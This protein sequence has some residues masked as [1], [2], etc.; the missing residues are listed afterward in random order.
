MTRFLIML[1]EQ[2]IFWTPTDPQP[3]PEMSLL[4]VLI[5]FEPKN[6]EWGNHYTHSCFALLTI[7]EFIEIQDTSAVQLW[8]VVSRTEA[9]R[10]RNKIWCGFSCFSV[11]QDISNITSHI[12][13]SQNVSWT[14]IFILTSRWRFECS[15]VIGIKYKWADWMRWW[16]W[17]SEMM[18]IS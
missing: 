11:T 13:V 10:K 4:I 7:H 9:A 15:T 5:I 17:V 6:A 1:A 2:Y 3:D 16:S 8:W 12:S 14:C 18:V